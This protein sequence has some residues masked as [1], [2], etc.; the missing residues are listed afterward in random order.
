[1][2][3]DVL[4]SATTET[5]M[6]ERV[7][8]IVDAIKTKDLKVEELSIRDIAEA[9]LGEAG[10]RA[11]AKQPNAAGFQMTQMQEAVAPVNLS[12]FSNITGQLIYQGVYDAYS[13][14]EYIGDTLVTNE[15]SR[16]DNTR[17]PG[18]DPIDDDAA[19]VDEGGE[20]QDV[21]FGEDYIDIPQ[22][23]KR[24]L[25]IGVTREAVFFDRTGQ[26]LEMARSVGE[27]LGLNREKRILKTVLGIDNSYKRKGT[28]VDTYITTGN[29]INDLTNALTDYTSFD[30]AMKA[31]ADMRDD[32]KDPEPIVVNPK[33]LL[34]NDAL[35]Y[36]TRNILRS[37]EI[38]V[39]P[40]VSNSASKMP[41]PYSGMLAQVGSPWVRKLLTGATTNSQTNSA[42]E[43]ATFWY[44]GDFKRAFRYRTLF[45]LSVIAAQ[46]DV[47]QFERDVVAQFRAD[48]RGVP[49]IWAPWYVI[50]CHG[51]LA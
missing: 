28:A 6:R 10:M 51:T 43:A 13:A 15:N 4:K 26:V 42:A 46:N 5:E 12:A 2:L 41:N 25:K 17:V 22:S 39:A 20:Y 19:I 33:Q 11:M 30:T 1:M 3:I 23:K 18:L 44:I 27:R 29:R 36:T 31:F 14:P 7:A 48:E 34:V 40:A 9:T 47:A 35:M 16:E 38:A 24:G 49:Y 32:R 37:T 8:V 50:R 21:K 45:P